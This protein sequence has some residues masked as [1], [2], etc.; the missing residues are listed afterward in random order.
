MSQVTKHRLAFLLALSLLSVAPL[1]GC[2]TEGPAEKAGEKIDAG[3]QKAKDA[4]DPPGPGE[5]VG[6]EID[7][8]TGK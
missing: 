7:K 1:A 4:I 2:G 5:K 8:A 6:R 3:V